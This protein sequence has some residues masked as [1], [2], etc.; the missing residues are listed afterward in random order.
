MRVLGTSAFMAT[1]Y[2]RLA[3]SGDYGVNWL[4]TRLAGTGAARDM[5]LTGRRVE[6]A[7][8]RA[9]G[10]AS[11][12]VD[13]AELQAAAR[14]TAR[15]LASSAGAAVR[16]IKQ[17]LDEAQHLELEASMD[18]EAERLIRLVDTDEHRQAVAA[19]MDRSQKSR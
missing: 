2:A 7:E 15:A 17:N 10:L 4:L 3:M 19:F 16:S 11:Q 9:L 12:I 6:A 8:C 1:G 18:R 5:M 14:R 13:D